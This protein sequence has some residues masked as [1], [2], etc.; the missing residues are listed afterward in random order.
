[1][2]PAE[3]PQILVY[4][5]IDEPTNGYYGGVVAFPS[6]RE[7]MIQALPRFGI[8][9]ATNVPAFTDPLSYQP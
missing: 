6:A 5:V 3:N 8:A 1:M 4:V 7:L 9:P 2:A